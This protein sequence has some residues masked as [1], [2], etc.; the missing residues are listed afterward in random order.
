MDQIKDIPI[1][2]KKRKVLLTV[3]LV[4][5]SILLLSTAGYIIYT[6]FL[7]QPEKPQEEEKPQEVEESNDRYYQGEVVI[8]LGDKELVLS[9]VEVFF[10]EDRYRLVKNLEDSKVLI[11]NAQRYA[12]TIYRID[13]YSNI[14]DVL[15]LDDNRETVTIDRI[16]YEYIRK[17]DG[18]EE[19]NAGHGTVIDPDDMADVNGYEA[20]QLISY[21]NTP[22]GGNFTDGEFRGLEES[23]IGNISCLFDLNKIYPEIQGAIEISIGSA[24]EGLNACN[25]LGSD[26]KFT[27]RDNIVTEKEQCYSLEQVYEYTEEIGEIDFNWVGSWHACES[28]GSGYC[29]RFVFYPNG[30]YVYISS[31]GNREQ[32]IWGVTTNSEDVRNVLNIAEGGN[33][34]N[35]RG[36]QFE[37]VNVF[38]E[39]SPYRF[40]NSLD[41]EQ[42]WQVSYNPDMWNPESGEECL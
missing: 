33:L 13:Y 29:D 9:N 12:S 10:E 38:G 40:S 8:E 5:L 7:N 27:L 17:V 11:N 23:S 24:D 3:L 26:F 22:L 36:L 25:L 6:N 1:K 42:Y 18:N 39:D 14:R 21:Y 41:G 16:T 34:D 4:I 35:L 37:S 32:G 15:P 28:V 19:Y 31:E 30:N 2:Q 20:Y